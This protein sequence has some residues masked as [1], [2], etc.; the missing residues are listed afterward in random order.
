MMHLPQHASDQHAADRYEKGTEQL[1]I[2]RCLSLI[3]QLL[4]TP[5]V[6][7]KKHTSGN[8]PKFAY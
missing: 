6:E 5:V 1:I 4:F 2:V 7:T 8:C 3:D